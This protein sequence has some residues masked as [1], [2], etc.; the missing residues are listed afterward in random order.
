MF[1]G[2]VALALSALSLPVARAA[3]PFVE[4]GVF[5]SFD[6]TAIAYTFFAPP[7]AGPQSRVPVVLMTHG[8]AGSRTRTPTGAVKDLLDR[9]YAVLTWDQRG[10]GE[11]GGEANIDA[12]DYEVR[13]VRGLIDL[14]ARRPEVLL[15]HPGDPRMGMIGASYAGGIQ[16]MVA[17]VDRR[18]DAI[19]PEIA[20][21]SLTQS[22]KPNGVLKLGWGNCSTAPAS[23]PGARSV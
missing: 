6:G 5:R 8:W 15:D 20:W 7:G 3:A 9:G 17:A 10:F 23:P 19:V 11:S 1:W 14:M 21:H 13:D 16:L 4:N 18:V 12:Q 22:L 2:A